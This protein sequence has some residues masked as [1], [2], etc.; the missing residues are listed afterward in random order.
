MRDVAP[1]LSSV[2]IGWQST[3]MKWTRVTSVGGVCV[4]NHSLQYGT[5]STSEGPTARPPR[6]PPVQLSLNM[7]RLVTEAFAEAP[8]KARLYF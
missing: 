6:Q 8:T 2:V 4:K 7:D 1:A 5:N 3:A